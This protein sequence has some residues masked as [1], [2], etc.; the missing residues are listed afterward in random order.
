MTLFDEPD[1]PAVCRLMVAY[2]GTGFRGFATQPE[3]RT[4]ASVLGRAIEKV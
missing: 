2:D 3:Q 4:V 1:G